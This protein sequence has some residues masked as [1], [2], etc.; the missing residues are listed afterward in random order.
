[1]K[2]FFDKPKGIILIDGAKCN[3]E[4]AT[5][6]KCFCIEYLPFDYSLKPIFYAC[7]G[8][9]ESVRELCFI[10]HGKDHI[11]K[12]CPT[13]KPISSDE[14]LYLQH[15]VDCQGKQSHCLSCKCKEGHKI[16][17]ETENEIHYLD[18]ASRVK[19]CDL[20]VAPLSNGQL[21]SIFAKL[22]NGKTYVCF[23]HYL[24]DYTPLLSLYCDE[25]S[26]SDDCLCV[27]DD[28]CDT[29]ARRCVRRIAFCDDSFVELSRH[30]EYSCQH[31]YVDELIPYVFLESLNCGDADCIQNCLSYSMKD[32]DCKT[33][34]GDF[35]EI[36][37]C[38][39]YTPYEVTLVYSS[40]E[41]FYTRTY[42]FRVSGG[43]ITKVDLL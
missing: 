39:K 13:K 16:V 7:A 32:F 27:L 22:E 15:I 14:E 35:I 4:Y 28:L 17:V 10:R 31:A 19:T 37:D 21:L 9:I 29:L 18:V 6:G 12:F 5:V 8:K 30:F 2:L 25:I 33:F 24:D 23:L 20:K 1:M 26:C 41:G 3:G 36:C 38:L 11:V 40:K 34:F 42:K 43:K